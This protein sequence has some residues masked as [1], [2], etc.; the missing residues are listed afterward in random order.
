LNVAIGYLSSVNNRLECVGMVVGLLKCQPGRW[1]YSRKFVSRTLK[2]TGEQGQHTLL[3]R[4]E[5][6]HFRNWA[7]I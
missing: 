1:S 7:Q 4:G 2:P 6:W 3:C 5:G